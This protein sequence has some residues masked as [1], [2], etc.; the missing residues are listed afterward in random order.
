MLKSRCAAI[1]LVAHC[2]ATFHLRQLYVATVYENKIF[3]EVP[4]EALADL[5]LEGQA[6][7]HIAKEARMALGLSGGYLAEEHSILAMLLCQYQSHWQQHD[8]LFYYQI[9]LYILVA[10]GVCM[11][12]LCRQHDENIAGHFGT[13]YTSELVAMKYYWPGMTCKIKAYTWA[14]LTCKCMCSVQH[15]PYGSMEPLPEPCS[16]WTCIIFDFIIGL[17]VSHQ[18]HHAKHHNVIIIVINWYTKQ[19]RSFP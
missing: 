18:E 7:D 11:E 13:K 8:V 4:L 19:A 17:P 9:R 15:R 3:K 10:G 6:E 5:I 14:N 2:N 16:P 12:V 1:I